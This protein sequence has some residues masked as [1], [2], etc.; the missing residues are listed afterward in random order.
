MN[1]ATYSSKT[2]TRTGTVKENI[3]SSSRW[4]VSRLHFQETGCFLCSRIDQS[5]VRLAI[6]KTALC[7]FVLCPMIS[8]EG[9]VGI[10]N[11]PGLPAA[12]AAL[13]SPYP[14]CS[15]CLC[16]RRVALAASRWAAQGTCLEFEAMATVVQ[17]GKS[18]LGGDVRLLLGTGSLWQLRPAADIGVDMDGKGADITSNGA[19]PTWGR[20]GWTRSWTT[21][22]S[23]RPCLVGS[24][25][26]PSF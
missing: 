2:S 20:M 3:S 13:I 9:V 21:F 14:T 1:P 16:W 4:N 19:Y 23:R 10:G 25:K 18:G 24:C 15:N 12:C 7:H 17:A 6:A 11:R 26:G 5:S 8:P 22:W